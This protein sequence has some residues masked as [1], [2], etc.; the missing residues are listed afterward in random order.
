MK[1]IYFF[2]VKV[3]F[4]LYTLVFWKLYFLKVFIYIYIFP[5]KENIYNAQYTYI[6][7]R[8]ILYIIS[9]VTKYTNFFNHY[10]YIKE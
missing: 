8:F 4:F 2:K 7:T 6:P 1:Y 3:Y 10:T 9:K 5:Q